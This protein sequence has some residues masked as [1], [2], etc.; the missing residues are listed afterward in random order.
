MSVA[1]TL[2][3]SNCAHVGDLAGYRA[4]AHAC[5]LA[6]ALPAKT[7]EPESVLQCTRAAPG[8]RDRCYRHGVAPPDG[9]LLQSR[10]EYEEQTKSNSGI[11]TAP[12]GH[13]KFLTNL[14]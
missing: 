3:C 5:A 13:S 7:S 1:E 14:D 10:Q 2:A 9:M 8:C 12:Y 11:S 4:A 6:A